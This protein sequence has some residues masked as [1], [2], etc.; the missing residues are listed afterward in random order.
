M[1]LS[2]F[3]PASKFCQSIEIDSH[4]V[5]VPIFTLYSFELLADSGPGKRHRGCISWYIRNSTLTHSYIPLLDLVR[6][7]PSPSSFS[8]VQITDTGGC[9]LGKLL[10]GG[11]AYDFH[12]E[13][14]T[15]WF[16]HIQPISSFNRSS[17]Q[18]PHDS[19]HQNS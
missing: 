12:R 9:I 17:I 8:H 13:F 7:L 15:I 4:P 19:R 18:Y 10:V 11:F 14:W 5:L 1:L 3:F 2:S 6:L 16:W